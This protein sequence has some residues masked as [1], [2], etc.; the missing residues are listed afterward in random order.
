M[1]ATRSLDRDRG[2]TTTRGRH[3]G[4]GRF[5]AATRFAAATAGQH[6]DSDA[7]L[8]W[9]TDPSEVD[10]APN[11]AD[12]PA[13][14]HD[15]EDGGIYDGDDAGLSAPRSSWIPW[16][17]L[18]IFLREGEL[19]YS[20]AL[21]EADRPGLERSLFHLG[22]GWEQTAKTLINTQGAALRC[23]TPLAAL[24]ALSPFAMS[25]LERS[26]GQGSRDRR[27]VLNTPFGLAPLWFFAQGRKDELFRDLERLGQAVMARRETRLTP[28]LIEELVRNPSVK[29]DS[30]RRAHGQALLAVAHNPGIVARHRSL[31]P[32]TTTGELLDDLGIVADVGRSAAVAAM[33]LAGAFDPPGLLIAASAHG[34]PRREATP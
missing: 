22:Q 32:L 20:V 12:V 14:Y 13:D 18:S 29:P 31:W 21:P 11:D 17:R 26:V 15:D 30:I 5:T 3:R 27:V 34:G 28:A 7:P 25:D 1:K 6:L 8:G 4:R 33:A 24:R 9:D 2:R 16:V 10:D 19:R 23:S